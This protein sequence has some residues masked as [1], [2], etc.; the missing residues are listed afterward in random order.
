M[1]YEQYLGEKRPYYREERDER[2][3]EEQEETHNEL[4]PQLALQL[5]EMGM[6]RDGTA[7]GDLTGKHQRRAGIGAQSKEERTVRRESN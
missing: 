3:Q 2:Y 4:H 5:D 1:E 6:Q 7:I